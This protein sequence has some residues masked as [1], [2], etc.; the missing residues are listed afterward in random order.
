MTKAQKRQR[1]EVALRDRAARVK[2]DREI[3]IMVNGGMSFREV[4]AQDGMPSAGQCHRIYTTALAETVETDPEKAKVKHLARLEQLIR[5][6][7]PR[8]MATASGNTPEQDRITLQYQNNL[9]KL[10]EL[11]AKLDGSFLTELDPAAFAGDVSWDQTKRKLAELHVAYLQR[12]E[13]DRQREGRAIEATATTNG[14][15]PAELAS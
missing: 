12:R 5:A 14:H 11:M 1:T 8:A 6:N 13:A 7:F 2:R 3:V 9:I 10:V 15:G 4:A